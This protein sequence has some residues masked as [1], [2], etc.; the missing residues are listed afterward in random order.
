MREMIEQ[1]RSLSGLSLQD[2]ATR[3]GITKSHLWDLE[4]GRATN[5]TIKTVGGLAKALCVPF[6][7]MAQGALNDAEGVTQ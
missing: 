6:T 5:P 1:H 7:S 2:V 4:Q 3:A